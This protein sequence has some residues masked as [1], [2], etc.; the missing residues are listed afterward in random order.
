MPEFNY[1]EARIAKNRVMATDHLSPEKWLA[2]VETLTTE[3]IRREM[4]RQ[5][6][7]AKLQLISIISILHLGLIVMIALMGIVIWRV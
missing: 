6:T 2:H 3:Q 1:Y 5:A 7:D 4:L